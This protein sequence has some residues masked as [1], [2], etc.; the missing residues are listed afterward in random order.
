MQSFALYILVSNPKSED[1][2]V[3]VVRIVTGYQFVDW[4]QGTIK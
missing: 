3:V 1:M 2:V 4:K